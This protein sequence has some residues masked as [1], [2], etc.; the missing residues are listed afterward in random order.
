METKVLEEKIFIENDLEKK[1]FYYYDWIDN[2]DIINANLDYF[3]KEVKWMEILLIL[4][5]Q[6]PII[7]YILENNIENIFAQIY[8]FLFL[9]AFISSLALVWLFFAFCLWIFFSTFLYLEFKK[10]VFIKNFYFYAWKINESENYSLLNPE[11]IKKIFSEKIWEKLKEEN[12]YFDKKRLETELILVEKYLFSDKSKNNFKNIFSWI[13]KR[14]WDFFKTEN[15][16]LKPLYFLLKIFV[17]LFW[18]III[19]FSVLSIF[20]W[21]IIFFYK[22]FFSIENIFEKIEKNVKILEKEAIYFKENI[23]NFQN[24]SKTIL[25]IW[26]SSKNILELSNKITKNFSQNSEISEKLKKILKEEIKN[27]FTKIDKILEKNIFESEEKLKEISWSQKFLVLEKRLILWL[28]SLK[29]Q[30]ENIEKYL[31]KF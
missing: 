11:I 21:N 30:K 16:F 25:K 15:I 26:K 3:L 4:A 14:I 8:T 6:T 18:I 31:E 22:N 28:K 5:L 19:Y 7:Y 13:F 10:I 20:I 1:W 27:I 9:P 23:E 29:I 24:Y 17:F 2:F 12:T